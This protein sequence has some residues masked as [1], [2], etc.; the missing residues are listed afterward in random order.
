LRTI[1]IETAAA[2]ENIDLFEMASRD[3]DMRKELE[4][5]S[6]IQSKLFPTHF[7]KLTTGQ[8]AGCCYP[9]RTTGGDYYDYVELPG[10]K[11]GLIMCD[12]PGKGMP[13]ALQ[14]ASLEKILGLQIPASSNLAEL[15]E[16]V[17]RELI[18]SS[19]SGKASTLF[20][21]DF[22][23]AT[24]RLE[25]INAG[26]PPPLVLAEQGS[27]FLDATGLPL[28]LFPEITHQARALV[29]PPGAM[30]LVYSDG[31]IDARNVS[32]ESFGRERLAGTLFRELASD[33]ERALARVVADI[34]DFEGDAL[35]EDDQTFL[36][37]KVYPE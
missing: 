15:V 32:G 5:A 34:R 18:A 36:L 30:L 24:R 14:A 33:A 21:G 23:G 4:V 8:L 6:D 25:Y 20:Y 16:R 13:A 29:L 7:P 3:R 11:I 28:G 31:A 19:G 35:L 37:F 12:V 26:H 2:L 22:D 9:A 27:Q 17:N 10:R 1:A